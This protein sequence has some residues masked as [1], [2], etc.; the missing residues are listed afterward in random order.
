MPKC[1]LAADVGGTN[2]RVA[3]VDTNG[4]ILIRE[5]S[6]TPNR[7]SAE[8]IC[9]FI[10]GIA[11][12]ILQEANRDSPVQKFGLALPAI[13]DY[14]MFAVSES[15][16]LPHLNGFQ[17][18]PYVVNKTGLDV[19]LENDATAATIG[20]HWLGAARD[21]ND[22]IGVTLGTGVG[23]GLIIE[24]DVF[25]GVD[26]TAGE[27]GH[28]CVEPEGPLCGCG[29][30]G[31]VEQFA[32]ATAIVRQAKERLRRVPS[33]P[34]HGLEHFTSADVFNAAKEGDKLSIEVFETAGYYL[35]IVLA[36]LVN[37]LNPEVIVIAGGVSAA[38][39]MFSVPM[40]KQVEKR[41]FQRPAERVNIVRGQLGDDAGILGAAKT[42]IAH[43]GKGSS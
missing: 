20:E 38:W 27:I 25:H 24:G 28:I 16:N 15:P 23:G 18:G 14:S 30:Y 43:A 5:E 37:L 41:A 10:S 39:E 26:G 21:A 36:G 22:V 6:D 17:I 42:V 9:D 35:G 3:L 7:G 8:E 1:V 2:V 33:S 13:I 32:S 12:N 19:K 4:K 40:L 34:L 29:S 31:C 11:N